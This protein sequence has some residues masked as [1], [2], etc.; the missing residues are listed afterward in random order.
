MRNERGEKRKGEIVRSEPE[1]SERR[2]RGGRSAK[3]DVLLWRKRSGERSGR[4]E[5]KSNG[6]EEMR[7]ACQ[8]GEEIQSIEAVDEMLRRRVNQSLRFLDHEFAFL[9]ICGI[10][11]L[12]GWEK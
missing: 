2:G 5:N 10:G 8:G 11:A 9:V 3:G 1:R 4:G 7:L 6:V 12:G